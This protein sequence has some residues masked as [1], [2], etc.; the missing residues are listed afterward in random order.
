MKILFTEEQRIEIKELAFS[1]KSKMDILNLLNHVNSVVYGSKYE[2]ID[3]KFLTYYA[4]PE[5]S[6]KRYDSFILKKKSGGERLIYV[7]VSSFKSILKGISLILDVLYTPNE[8]AIGFVSGRSIVNN[9][10]FHKNKNYVFN[11][12]LKDFFHSFDLNRVKLAL[13]SP[14]L[15]LDKKNEKL[16][17]FLAS[18]C[19]HPIEINGSIKCVLPQGSPSSPIITNFIC[20]NLDRRLNGLA[21]RF[22]SKYSRY[23]DDITFSSDQN[24]FKKPSFQNELK[25]IIE[26]DQKLIINTQKTR[27]LPKGSSQQVTGLIVNEKVN[28][29]S[30]YIKKIRMWIYYLETYGIEKTE[31]IFKRDY[32]LE[33]GH[34][35]K[36]TSRVLNVIEGK[37]LYLKM[38][39]GVNDSTYIKLSERFNIIIGKKD[40]IDVL[41]QTWEKEGIEKAISYHEIFI[42]NG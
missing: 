25:R 18:L 31:E 34:V 22:K 2:K 23:A 5:F 17:F 21:K 33:K 7:P 19:T 16:A 39:K 26:V 1:L 30:S 15:N 37:L 10:Q 24:I 14:P 13:M 35:K 36:Y 27:L 42:K 29:S 38:V 20:Q 9:A 4:N 28:V 40:P 11:I 41:I 8:F 32:I 6:K 3:L 12:D